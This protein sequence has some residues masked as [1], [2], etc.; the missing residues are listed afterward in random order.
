MRNL[1]SQQ[2]GLLWHLMRFTL[3]STTESYIA[4]SS[5]FFSVFV[6]GCVAFFFFH[7]SGR[8]GFLE[9]TFSSLSII[10]SFTHIRTHAHSFVTLNGITHIES[11]LWT[12]LSWFGTFTLTRSHTG[13]RSAIQIGIGQVY[14]FVYAFTY[15]WSILM[16]FFPGEFSTFS[17]SLLLLSIAGSRNVSSFRQFGNNLL[18]RLHLCWLYFYFIFVRLCIYVTIW[19]V[20]L[21]LS[22]NCL[23]NCNKLSHQHNITRSVTKSKQSIS[24]VWATGCRHWTATLL[25]FSAYRHF[26]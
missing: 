6:F 9:A 20:P 16:S 18:K 12:V 21:N 3:V 2:F 22:P 25:V 19:C 11:K 17:C 23:V 1:N 24:F 10:R 8:C 26:C 4:Y 5:C 15:T 13:Y 14:K 7:Y